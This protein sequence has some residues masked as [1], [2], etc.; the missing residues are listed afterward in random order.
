[1]KNFDAV[2]VFD[3]GATFFTCDKCGQEYGWT[4]AYF[5][6]SKGQEYFDNSTEKIVVADMDLCRDCNGVN[7]RRTDN[8]MIDAEI[9]SLNEKTKSIVGI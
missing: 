3:F 5:S 8:G 2:S 4:N 1:M 6:S 7:A 9:A